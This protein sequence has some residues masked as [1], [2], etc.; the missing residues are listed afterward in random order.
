MTALLHRSIVDDP[1]KTCFDT[2]HRSRARQ[3]LHSTYNMAPTPR[4]MR[5]QV[6]GECIFIINAVTCDIILD[7][8]LI[9]LQICQYVPPHYNTLLMQSFNTI[10]DYHIDP[11]HFQYT[12]TCR[13][14]FQCGFFRPPQDSGI[15]LRARR[16]LAP[17]CS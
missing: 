15:F 12:T 4:M 14:F 9:N 10:S 8:F 16:S 3:P 7:V 5:C 11:D 1:V 2:Y 17:R 6:F 13:I